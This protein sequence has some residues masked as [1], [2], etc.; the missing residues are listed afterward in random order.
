[1]ILWKSAGCLNVDEARKTWEKSPRVHIYKERKRKFHLN[2]S[3][4][5]DTV[6][7]MHPETNLISL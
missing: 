4:P 3:E 5:I 6:V 2:I 1:M 7:M